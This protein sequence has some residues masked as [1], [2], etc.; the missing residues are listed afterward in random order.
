[1]SKQPRKQRTERRT[2]PL[3]R[4]QKQLRATLSADLRETY[5]TRN[6]RVNAGDSVEIMRGDDAGHEGEV[7]EVDVR[8]MALH[9]E[10]VTVETAEGEEVPRPVD[11]SNVRITSLDL[12]DEVR[13][14]R[15]EGESE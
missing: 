2:A 9:V 7:L 3:H 1:M 11:A 4:R 8:E 6:A 5:D 13:R 12:S 10:E 14:N 15:L